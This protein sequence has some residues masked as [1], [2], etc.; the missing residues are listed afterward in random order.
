M[1]LREQDLPK[2]IPS[3]SF[4]DLK[5]E[6]LYFVS[7]AEIIDLESLHIAATVIVAKEDFLHMY[8]TVNN[9]NE[10]I[11]RWIDEYGHFDSKFTIHE[12]QYLLFTNSIYDIQPQLWY[13]P[14]ELGVL[15]LDYI[16]FD[17]KFCGGEVEKTVQQLIAEAKK[18]VRIGSVD[19]CRSELSDDDLF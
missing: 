6:Y 1:P 9:H 19:E 7:K 15:S 17:T 5:D 2:T 3:K 18:I 10:Y 14:V 13:N 16:Q 12:I 11:I 4:D 8:I